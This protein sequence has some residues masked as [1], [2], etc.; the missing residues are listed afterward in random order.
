MTRV[1]ERMED[2]LTEAWALLQAG[3]RAAAAARLAPVLGR[4]P[5]AC[6][7]ETCL[8]DAAPLLAV[9]EALP[10]ASR[11]QEAKLA[12]AL[13]VEAGHRRHG[14]LVEAMAERA[15]LQDAFIA[16]FE[17]TPVMERL[18]AF[19]GA[20][21]GRAVAGLATTRMRPGLIGMALFRHDITFADGGPPL[22]V[23]EK[24]MRTEKRDLRRVRAEHLLFAHVEAERLMAPR[25]F[26]TL[27]AE[28]FVSIFQAFFDGAPLPI[29]RW[30]ATHDELL[31]RYWALVPPAGLAKAP[32]LV[33][34]FLD[35]LKQLAA[36]SLPSG[37]EPHLRAYSV[38][39]VALILTRRFDQIVAVLHA[40][41]L[42]VFHDDMHC[43]NI[44]VDAEGS[45]TIIDWDHWAL[46]PI[47][48]GWRFYV[49]DESLPEPEVDRIEWARALPPEATGRN[50][51]LMASLWGWHKALRDHKLE[52]AARWLEKL[53]RHA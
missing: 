40:M 48:T 38:D 8:D 13:L 22:S 35:R 11:W 3:D 23:V 32:S 16:R 4:P 31:Y 28:P 39:D 14:W 33:P 17:A 5:E 2:A 12:Y 20:R 29:E 9:A 6:L 10:A 7:P 1:A 27:E 43:G 19:L 51:M 37:V 41:P 15:I 34:V 46:A 47:G 26:G 50:L 42:F 52:L 36:R 53:V 44:L 24:V 25:H 21:I 30:M 45:M 49:T 18:G